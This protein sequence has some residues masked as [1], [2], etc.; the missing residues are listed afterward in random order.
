[1][2]PQGC[3]AATG[4]K[5]TKV[6]VPVELLTTTG[7]E[8]PTT[9]PAARAT[10]EDGEF[11]KTV[12]P[13]AGGLFR[14]TTEH[15]SGRRIRRSQ[16]DPHNLTRHR[17]MRSTSFPKKTVPGKTDLNKQIDEELRLN[18]CRSLNAGRRVAAQLHESRDT[19]LDGTPEQKARSHRDVEQ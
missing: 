16:Q 19:L 8:E 13:R 9:V 10:S 18:V 11:W 1:M 6:T 4:L 3:D 7:C 12:R 15:D 2:Q 17:K 5:I 14:L